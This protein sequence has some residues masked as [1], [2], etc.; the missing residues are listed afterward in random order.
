VS[1]L[2][3]N[4]P[5]PKQAS[6]ATRLWQGTGRRMDRLGLQQAC[7][8]AGA[9]A[10]IIVGQWSE[11]EPYR[12]PNPMTPMLS[13]M[14]SP[15]VGGSSIGGGSMM[16]AGSVIGGGSMM[17]APTIASPVMGGAA[18]PYAYDDDLYRRRHRRR[19]RH[20]TVIQ[21]QPPPTIINVGGGAGPQPFPVQVGYSGVQPG[22]PLSSSPYPGAGVT[23]GASS[24]GTGAY[25]GYGA[26]SAVGVGG[27]PGGYGTTTAI[28]AT[29]Y[30]SSLGGFGVGAGLGASNMMGGMHLGGSVL[31]PLPPSMQASYQAQMAAQYPN[32]M[33]NIG[34]IVPGQGFGGPIVIPPPHRH[35]HRSRERSR[36]PSRERDYERRR[37]RRN[38]D[39]GYGS[40]FGPPAS[41]YG[42]R[43]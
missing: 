34:G 17:G 5:T 27:Y 29:G 14:G 21:S 26:G 16:G 12:S 40:M 31:N 25:G 7:D 23:Y 20:S 35:H 38:S 28:P 33:P 6:S 1:L 24:V 2:I 3:R 11:N 15:M 8:A 39:V 36:E 10:S 32:A 19:R 18:D 22:V 30:G 13:A 42:G 37:M 43:Y 41:A 9:T 4:M